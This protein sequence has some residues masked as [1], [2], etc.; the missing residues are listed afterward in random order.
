MVA[1]VLESAVI[2]VVTAALY[3]QLFILFSETSL[4]CIALCLT[5]LDYV[6][7]I[8]WSAMEMQQALLIPGLSSPIGAFHLN[9]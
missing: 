4:G 5:S 6:H 3:L 9:I 1:A 2:P 8:L 7:G